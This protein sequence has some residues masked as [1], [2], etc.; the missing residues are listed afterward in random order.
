MNNISD[1]TLRWACRRGMLELD[2]VLLPYL[3][4]HLSLLDQHQRVELW[5]LLQYDDPWLFQC[6]V[7]K[8]IAAD[9]PHHALLMQMTQYDYSI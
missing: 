1:A 6:L 8:K 4:A 2:L 5:Q 3:E 7:L 9:S